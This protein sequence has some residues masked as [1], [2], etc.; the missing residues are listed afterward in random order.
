[1][2]KER[3]KGSKQGKERRD[4]RGKA[5]LF[6]FFFTIFMAKLRCRVAEKEK[7]QSTEDIRKM[8]ST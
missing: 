8:S 7:E 3:S 2:N 1:M 5:A 4:S 6:R